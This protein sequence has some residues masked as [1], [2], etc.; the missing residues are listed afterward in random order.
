MNGYGLHHIHARRRVARGLEPFPSKH[1]AKRLF[2]FLMFGVGVVQPLA[3]LPQIKTIY[4]DHSTM[5]VS[6]TTWM[7][8]SV[9]NFLW[10][11]YGIIHRVIPMVIANVLL[12]ALD[13]AIV[14]GAL[15][16]V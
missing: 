9:F 1:W 3:L 7:L 5:G 11:T 4:I 8:L 16:Y 13:V 15:G 10:A 12:F 6:I 2:D 14:V